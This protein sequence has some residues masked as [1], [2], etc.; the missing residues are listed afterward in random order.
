MIFLG[1]PPALSGAPIESA[2]S[3]SQLQPFGSAECN[4]LG[5]TK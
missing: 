5:G 4:D 3:G 2:L 1:K